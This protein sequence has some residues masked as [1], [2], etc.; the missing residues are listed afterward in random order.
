[1]SWAERWEKA[2]ANRARYRRLQSRMVVI[3]IGGICAAAG[4]GNLYSDIR[5]QISG[6]PATATLVEHI[7]QCTVE[8]QRV[9]QE[10]KKEKM[11]CALA[12]EFQRRVGPN[13]IGLTRD[14]IARV[15]VRRADGPVYE[16]SVDDVKLGTYSVAVGTTV[17]VV[18]TPDNPSDVRPVMSWQ[19]VKVP[20]ILLAIGVPFLAL[21]LLGPLAALFG[22]ASGGRRSRDADEAVSVPSGR[23]APASTRAPGPGDGSHGQSR[24]NTPAS[25]DT[26]SRP[27]GAPPRPAFGMRNR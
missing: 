14:F 8:Y 22:W 27:T 20:L 6:R 18:Y 21:A 23:P 4:A 1:M 11:P 19:T 7:Q 26:D 5:H 3:M 25:V 24:P 2:K 12:E 16:A 17:P 9:G 10:K 13:K 15:Q